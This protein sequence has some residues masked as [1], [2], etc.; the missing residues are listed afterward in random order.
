MDLDYFIAGVPPGPLFRMS[1]DD[2]VEMVNSSTD[3]ETKQ[4]PIPE[5]C[6]IALV[7]Y[8]EAFFKNEFAAIVNIC[9]Q[10]L[11]SFCSK[12]PDT[13]VGIKDLM[14][15]DLDTKN[16]LGFV[17]AEKYDFGSPKTINNL[18]FDLLSVTLFS[19]DESK[20]Y[21]RLLNDR[22]LLVHYGGIYTMRYH[23]QNF[24]KQEV[25]NRIFFDSLTVSKDDCLKWATF[26]HQMVGKTISVCHRSIVDSLKKEKVKLSK[27]RRGAFKFLNWYE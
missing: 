15:I 4:N 16:R 24:K 9:P 27:E 13:S 14:S 22:N 10:V 18:Y 26:V 23:E 2:L 3:D 17:I 21:D 20:K 1:F 12:R 25:G 11:K 6:L 7:A 5:V 8:F 19:K